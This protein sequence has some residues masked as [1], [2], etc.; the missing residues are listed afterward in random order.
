MRVSFRVTTLISLIGAVLLGAVGLW[1]VRRDP[2]ATPVLTLL[3]NRQGAAVLAQGTPVV[4]DVYLTGTRRGRQTRI[5]SSASPWH[6]LVLLEHVETKELLPWRT[7]VLGA[8]RATEYGF[9][10]GRPAVTQHDA[11]A[12]RIGG[13]GRVQKVT[14]AVA[15]EDSAPIA[16]GVYH[17]RAVLETP[18]WE[19]R[20]WRGLVASAPVTLTIAAG[21]GGSDPSLEAARLTESARFYL[22][23]QRFDDAHRAASELL[24]REPE[25]ADAYILIGDALAGSGRNRE[26]LE[27]YWSAS[28]LIPKRYEQPAALRERISRSTSAMSARSSR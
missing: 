3:V 19:F 27:A 26:A 14:I 5:G 10:E 13:V 11:S 24:Q 12:A 22:S 15:P 21:P 7:T 23:A 16:P 1:M 20:G 9:A 8:P 25:S 17:V 4:F 28:R 18:F 2:P 6:R